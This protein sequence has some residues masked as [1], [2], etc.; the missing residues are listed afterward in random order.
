MESS[1]SL[2]NVPLFA[3]GSNLSVEQMRDRHVQWDGDRV[4]VA[5]LEAY[6]LIFRGKSTNPKYHCGGLADVDAE[7]RSRVLGVVYWTDGDLARLDRAEGVYSPYPLGC[8]RIHIPVRARA[9]LIAAETYVRK[10]KDT[11]NPPHEAYLRKII[12]GARDHHLPEEWINE[13]RHTATR[14]SKKARI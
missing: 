13:I 12:E 3:F 14:S 8:C 1:P 4:E 7:P 9:G 11:P 6:S 10:F 5:Q 2:F